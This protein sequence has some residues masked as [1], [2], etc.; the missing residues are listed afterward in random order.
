MAKNQDDWHKLLFA[1]FAYNN[2]LH[3]STGSTP[4]RLNY[5]FDPNLPSSFEV[6][7]A[8]H[9]KN[10]KSQ[11]GWEDYKKIQV[12]K[13]ALILRVHNRGSKPMLTQKGVR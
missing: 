11:E 7:E 3:E 4:F 5:G 10:P 6:F 8:M 1:E 9:P 2:S 13:Q 12:A